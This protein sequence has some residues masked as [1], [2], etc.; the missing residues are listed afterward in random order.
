[1][2]IAKETPERLQIWFWD[3]SGFSL[4]VNR[5][6]TWT[7]KGKRKKVSGR[8]RKGRFS[9]MGGVRLSDKKRIVD[10]ISKGTGD[11]FF[12]V[13]HGFYDEVK[14]EW[15]GE[16]RSIDDFER[17][18]PKI[19]IILDNASIHKKEEILEKIAKEMPNIVLEFLPPYSPDYNLIELVWHSA[20]EFIANRLFKSIEDLE[21]LVHNLLNEGELVI[22]W[23]RNIKNK[24]NTVNAI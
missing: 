20:K 5:R 2:R 15:A 4:R 1:M 16:D 3:E 23:D 12:S 7:K 11:S 6:K 17:I 10:F 21:A 18:G 8:R 9:V 14:Q 22:N 19:L 13:L 24:G